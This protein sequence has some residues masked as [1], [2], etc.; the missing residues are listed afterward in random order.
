LTG[1]AAWQGIIRI[2]NSISGTS[3]LYLGALIA[4]VDFVQLLNVRQKLLQTRMK[5]YKELRGE[6]PEPLSN[7]GHAFSGL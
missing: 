5:I 4:K 2:Q 6:T 7:L 3:V 1:Q